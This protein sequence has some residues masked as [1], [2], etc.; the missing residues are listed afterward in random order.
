[1][2]HRTIDEGHLGALAGL[3]VTE[4]YLA[5]AVVLAGRYADALGVGTGIE[6]RA[7]IPVLARVAGGQERV[8]AFSVGGAGVHGTSQAIVAVVGNSDALALR[9]RVFART[10]VPVIAGRAPGH[11]RAAQLQVAAVDRAGVAIIAVQADGGALPFVAGA[12]D[13]AGAAGNA[14]RAV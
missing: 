8:A 1:M 10:C 11:M 3:G 4:R 13:K 14:R 2:A 6:Q 12:G 5:G 7:H 9:A